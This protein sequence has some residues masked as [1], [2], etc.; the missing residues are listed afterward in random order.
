MGELFSE[1]DQ[2]ALAAMTDFMLTASEKVP[3]VG[4]PIS[5]Y[6][7]AAKL[8]EDSFNEKLSRGK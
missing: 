4:V 3:F 2:S 1:K 6:Q 7:A 5:L 8:E